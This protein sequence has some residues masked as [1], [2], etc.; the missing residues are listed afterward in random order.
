M[1]K[2]GVIIVN[3]SIVT[4]KVTRDDLK[5]VYAPLSDIAKEAG[6]IMTANIVSLAIYAKATG[7]VSIDT[8]KK[9]LPVSIKRKALID[10]NLSAIDAGV[11]FYDKNYPQGI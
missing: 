6:A 8:I 4:R 5:V 7:A 10:T 9:V 2:G 1:Q 3:S 11:A